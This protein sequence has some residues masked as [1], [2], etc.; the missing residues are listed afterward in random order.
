[1]SSD[2]KEQRE[3]NKQAV[4]SAIEMALLNYTRGKVKSKKQRWNASP[5]ERQRVREFRVV[6]PVD[7]DVTLANGVRQAYLD[8]M[9]TFN[10]GI[11][12]VEAG[13]LILMPQRE[14]EDADPLPAKRSVSHAELRAEEETAGLSDDA[15]EAAAQQA[16]REYEEAMAQLEQIRKARAR[17]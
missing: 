13:N 14:G 9:A 12:R 6:D 17:R 8:D 3:A 10:H 2:N 4:S 1:M 5:A 11:M 7:G 16:Q 15:L